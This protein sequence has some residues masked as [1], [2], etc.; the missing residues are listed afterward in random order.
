MPDLIPEPRIPT[1]PRP[2]AAARTRRNHQ[3]S[4]AKAIL[5]ATFDFSMREYRNLYGLLNDR[6]KSI[7]LAASARRR[8]ATA[9]VRGVGPGCG[10]LA[11]AGGLLLEVAPD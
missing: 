6:G 8:L 7:T 1:S 2:S 9:G 5:H 3:S 4:R 10:R 11:A